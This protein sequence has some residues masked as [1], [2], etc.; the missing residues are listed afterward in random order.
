MHGGVASSFD[1]VAQSLYIG[2]MKTSISISLPE[3][4]KNWVD[5]QVAAGGFRTTREFF[6][7]VLREEQQRRL[8]QE[9]DRRLHEAL[10]SGPA[11]PM[12]KVDWEKIRR[13]GRKRLAVK[14]RKAHAAAD[15]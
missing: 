15:R 11:T 9:I 12:T 3:A 5:E 6:R 8:R 10:D 2:G 4:L 14:K 1:R 13:E 7:H